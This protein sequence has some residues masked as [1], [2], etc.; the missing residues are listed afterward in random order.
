IEAVSSASARLSIRETLEEL[1]DIKIEFGTA[2]VP[3]SVRETYGK[4]TSVEET[5]GGFRAVVRF[6]S[7]V[8]DMCRIF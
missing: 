5:D 2:S 1:D 6:T 3:S 7:I 4:V 8:P